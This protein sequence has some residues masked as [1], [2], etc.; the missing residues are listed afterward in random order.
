MSQGWLEGILFCLAGEMIAACTEVSR[1]E[2]RTSD[3]FALQVEVVLECV[4]ELR[5]VSH[6]KRK[7]RLCEHS[8]L[9]VG[10]TRKDQR[11]YAEKRRQKPID[12]KQDYRELIAK[13]STSAA[14]YGLAVTGD[15]PRE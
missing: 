10:K 9:G 3:D 14:Q 5:I 2:N 1:A 12:T 4:G 6:L 15:G 11:L 8:I 13:D 7:Y